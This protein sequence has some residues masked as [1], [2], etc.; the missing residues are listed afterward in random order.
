M[1][2]PT[3]TPLSPGTQSVLN[4]WLS[5]FSRRQ[6]LLGDPADLA[7]A[8]RAAAPQMEFVQDAQ[9]LHAMAAELEGQADG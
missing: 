7:A 5:S 4:T 6:L 1:I 3:P 8:F 9:R 2:D